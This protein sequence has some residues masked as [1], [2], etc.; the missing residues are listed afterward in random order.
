M[1]TGVIR[2]ASTMMSS[3]IALTLGAAAAL[4]GPGLAMA[5]TADPTPAPTAEPSAEPGLD[6]P[7]DVRLFGSADRNVYR[8]TARVN[9]EIITETDVEQRV[10]LTRIANGGDIPA[11]Q[12]QALKQ[13]V[14]ATLVDEKLQI[15]E[16]AA[17]KIEITDEDVKQRYDQLA[18]QF[19]QTPQ[20]FSTYLIKNGASRTSL[21]HQIRGQLAWDKLLSRNVEPFTNVSV[22][23][24][25]SIIDRLKAAKGTDEYHLAEIYLSATPSTA[26]ATFDN[27]LKVIDQIKKGG[28]FQTYARQFSEAST[29]AVGG[30]LGWIRL[31]QLP[32]PLAEAAASMQPGQLAGPVRVEGGV[33]IVYLADRRKVLTTD[34]RDA[35]LSLKQITMALSTTATA[36][37]AN[38]KASQFAEAT[39]NIAGCGVAD[40]VAARIGATIVSRDQIAMRDLPTPLQA[41]LAALPIGRTTQPFGSQDKGIS[42]LVLC[43]REMGGDA[44]APNPAEVER[45]IVQDKVAKRA[46]RYM[47]DLRRDAI[48]EYS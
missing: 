25:S 3:A 38:A 17:N 47:R 21:Y 28:S 2:F 40:E 34:A 9:G 12:I 39:R 7:R 41:T 32:Q 43:G 23:E 46:K 11:D 37:E 27:A 48:I 13:Q 8:P 14:F 16:A 10:A 30:D 44:A 5:Q 19:G 20:Q 6:I 35:V 24:V 29:A 36:A 31:A 18:R 26:Q 4:G 1:R 33:S 22:D 15:Q 42:V 45:G